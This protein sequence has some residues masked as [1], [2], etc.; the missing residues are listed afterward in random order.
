MGQKADLYERWVL[1][2]ARMEGRLLV[3]DLVAVERVA[4]RLVLL[5]AEF[6]TEVERE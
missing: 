4:A 2:T 6:E 3:V 5:E 1:E